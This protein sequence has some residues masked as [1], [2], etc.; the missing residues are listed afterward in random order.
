[1]R[2]PERQNRTQDDRLPVRKCLQ[3]WPAVQM[4]G[5]IDVEGVSRIVP[6]N[7]PVRR[8]CQYATP[9]RSRK[10]VNHA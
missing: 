10:G 7:R 8:S 6:S 1:M 3:V 4:Q 9:L 2:M 5:R